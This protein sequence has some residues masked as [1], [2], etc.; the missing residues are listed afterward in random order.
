M[1]TTKW[2]SDATTE[3]NEQISTYES[4][5]RQQA[6]ALANSHITGM[7]AQIATVTIKEVYDP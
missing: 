5:I 3:V 1:P 4:Y 2:N 7:G 6:E